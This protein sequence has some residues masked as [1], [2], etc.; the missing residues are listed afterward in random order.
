MLHKREGADRW[1]AFARPAKKLARRRPHPL[2]RGRRE[3]G[4][5][6]RAPRRRGRGEGRG[7]RGAAR[8][9]PSRA[10]SSTRRSRGSAR[11]R[12]RPTSPAGARPTSATGATTRRSTPA[13]RAPSRRRRPG[14]HFTD[15]LF[16]RL[17][18]RGIARHTVTLHVGAG[19]FLPVKADDTADHRMHAEWGDVSAG[20]GR[21]PERRRARGGG[22]IVAVG[23]T[24]LRLLESAARRGRHDRAVLGRHGDLHHA[25]L[26]LPRGRRPD[27]ELPPAAL[28]PVH[29]GLGLRRARQHAGGLCARDRTGYRFYSYGD[30]SLLFRAGRSARHERRTSSP[31]RSPRP[32]AR[33][34]RARSAC[35]AASSARPP[36]CRSA[37]PATVKAMYPDQVKALGADVVLGNTYH[38]ML[39]PG[40]E[41]VARA[42]R[43]AQVHELA[44][45][46]PDRFRRLPGHV[47]R[48]AA[49]DRRDRRHLPVAHRRLDP[50]PDARSARSRSRACSAPTSRC[51]STNACGCPA[52]EEAAEKAMRLSLRWAE[53]CRVAFGDQPGRALFGIVQG[54]AVERLRVESARELVALDLK[55]YAIGGLAVGEPQDV[56]LR[57]IETVEPHL[58]TGQ[59]ALPD[60]RR[61]AGRHRGSR[62]ARH[63]HVRLRDADPGRPPRQVFTRHGRLNLRNARHADDPSPA[64][65]RIEDAPPRTPIRAPIS[66]TSSARTR[67]SA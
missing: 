11:C 51:S 52:A 59:A 13:R 21:G 31:S 49:Q 63:R 36:S 26:P 28:D 66:T 12:C 37:R 22:R 45:S 8:A 46:D 65:C 57:M 67:S 10:R 62:A 54:G 48:G 19:T 35:R 24:A 29:A 2:R 7:R 47:A 14:L 58:P 20:D 55:G 18:A 17:D 15:D 6:A 34:A 40:A 30:A 5:R 43:P 61:H 39:R 41:R 56:M 42:R 9:S 53:R 4:L 33:P 25:G 27:D 3:H 64:R 23:T 60:G 16:R 38:L 1:R 32:T 44:L 50:R